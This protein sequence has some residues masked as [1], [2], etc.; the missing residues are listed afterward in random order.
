[1]LLG[2]LGPAAASATIAI[3]PASDTVTTS[4]LSLAF[5]PAAGNVERLDSVRWTDSNGAQGPN[6]ATNSGPG[7]GR[8]SVGLLGARGLGRRRTAADRRR[9]TGTWTP[10]G[11]RTVEITSSRRSCARATASSRRYGRYTFFDVGGAANKVRVERRISFSAST[12]NYPTISMRAYVPEM[13]ASTARSSANLPGT[14]LV[15]D[16]TST[17]THSFETSWNQ[18]WIALNNPATNAGVLILRDPRPLIPPDHHRGQRRRRLLVGRSAQAGRRL[19]AAVTGAEWLCFTTPTRGRSPS[20]PRPTSRRS[21]RSSPSR[22]TGAATVSGTVAVGS[23]MTAT[24]GVGQNVRSLQWQRCVGAACT[25]I[26]GAT[27]LTYDITGDAVA[28]LRRHR[29]RPAARRHR[30]VGADRRC[31]QPP[32]NTGLPVVTGEARGARR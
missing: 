8:R 4:R 22:S 7:C 24:T 27:A 5:G 21:A 11:R 6:L 1:V 29:R 2:G 26:A 3:N 20:V 15:T 14:G 17:G 19:D 13:P 28:A 23:T 16:A 32:Q 9:H 12:P 18:T 10:R 31:H 30:L 25:P